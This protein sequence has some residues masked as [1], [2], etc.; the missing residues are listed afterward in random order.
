VILNVYAK[1]VVAFL[2]SLALVLIQSVTDVY[3]GGITGYEWLG[4]AAILVGPAGLVAALGNSP[5]SPATKALVQQ[6]CAVV[7]I[8]VQGIQ[9]VYNGGITTQEWLGIGILL[10]SSLAVYFVPNRGSAVAARHVR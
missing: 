10:L 1:A 9:G 2:I 5:F 3:A 8:L 6:V 7:I 4:I